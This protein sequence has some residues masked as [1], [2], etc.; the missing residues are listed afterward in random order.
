MAKIAISVLNTDVIHVFIY[1]LNPEQ[2]E[3]ILGGVYPYSFF[4][5]N[6]TDSLY[7]GGAVRADQRLYAVGAYSTN[8]SDNKYDTVD[9]SRSIYNT[10]IY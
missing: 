9:Y 5:M 8:V 2:A 4:M 6:T 3:T 7:I 1:N 10:F